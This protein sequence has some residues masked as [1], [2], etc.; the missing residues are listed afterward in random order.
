MRDLR[1]SVTDRCNLRCTYC[2]PAEIFDKDHAF[3]PRGEIL[4][5]EEI[6]RLARIFV[7][8]G[9]KKLRI[10]GGEPTLRR[11]LP[12][13]IAQLRAIEGVEDVALTTNGLLLTKLATHLRAAGLDRLTV[14]LDSLDDAIFGRINGRGVHVQAV[15]DG[16]AAAEAAGFERLKINM[17]VQRSVNDHEVVS[18]AKHFKNTGHIVRFIE[19]MDVGTTNGWRMDLVVP[20]RDVIARIGAEMPLEPI[21]PNYRGEVAARYRYKD[22]MGE[23]GIISSVTVPFCGTCNR[24]RLSAKGELFTCLFAG[25]G[26][27]LRALLRNGTSDAGIEAAVR[28]IWTKRDDRYSEIRTAL[29]AGG[30]GSKRVEMSYIGG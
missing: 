26:N 22:G 30:A 16:I 27:D 5:Y 21:D 17:V 12:G 20:A 9:V 19:F 25:R 8:L 24:A 15:L 13:L 28:T 4:S 6:V 10:T 23:I 14:S 11:D 7:G 29:T 2:M 18:M 3:L 1:I